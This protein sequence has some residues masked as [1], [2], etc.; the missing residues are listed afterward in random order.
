MLVIV[1]MLNSSCKKTLTPAEYDQFI[2]DPDNG[3]RKTEIIGD[4][5]VSALYETSE[6]IHSRESNISSRSPTDRQSDLDKYE[7][8]QFRIKHIPGGNILESNQDEFNNMNS[9]IQHY[10]FEA[11]N[12]FFLVNGND[13]LPCKLSHYSRN[14]NLTPTVDLSLTFD[15]TDPQHDLKLIY[16][17]NQFNLGKIKF[18]FHREDIEN[19][20]NVENSKSR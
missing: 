12:D 19:A 5:E 3:L 9:R 10:S 6:Y 18:V 7:H 4:Y 16:A 17:D 14:Y 13:T 20:P 2:H 1:S 8:F 15:K 11:Q